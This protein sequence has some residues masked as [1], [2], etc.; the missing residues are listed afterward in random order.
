M[1]KVIA[2]FGSDDRRKK[3]ARGKIRP[4]G[5]REERAPTWRDR[6]SLYAACRNPAARFDALIVFISIYLQPFPCLSTMVARSPA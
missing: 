2:E 6:T 1:L 5:C 3:P 4:L